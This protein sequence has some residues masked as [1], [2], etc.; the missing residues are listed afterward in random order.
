MNSTQHPDG[1]QC[2]RDAC[3]QARAVRP[4]DER[5][6]R[7]CYFAVI[8]ATSPRWGPSLAERKRARRATP[9]EA[10]E[11]AQRVVAAERDRQWQA[12]LA[13]LTARRSQPRSTGS[14]IDRL[15][16]PEMVA[17][18]RSHGLSREEH[19]ELLERY[20]RPVLEERFT[21]IPP[22]LR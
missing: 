1:C 20:A 2:D 22:R 15:D 18:R 10:A 3:R 14:P 21:P 9:A 11:W 12:T 19:R 5:E 13:D 8:Q 17:Y 4:R 16:R 7:A 6:M